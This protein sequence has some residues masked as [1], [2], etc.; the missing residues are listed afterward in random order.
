MKC[1]TNHR[2]E[3]IALA[4]DRSIEIGDALELK[5]DWWN[6]IG[7][8]MEDPLKLNCRYR[9]LLEPQ[10]IEVDGQRMYTLSKRYYHR[11]PKDF[12]LVSE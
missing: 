9:V 4:Q 6:I 10:I 2:I 3:T 5:N 11:S 12:K 1:N 7:A 8:E